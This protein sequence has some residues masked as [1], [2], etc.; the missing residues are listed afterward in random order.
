MFMRQRKP[1]MRYLGGISGGG[2]LK[3]DGEEITRVSYELDGF[4]MEPAGVTRCGEIRID[5]DALKGV[6]GRDGVQLL[7]DDGRLFDLSFSDKELIPAADAVH[8]D[9]TGGMSAKPGKQR[10]RQIPIRAPHSPG[11]RS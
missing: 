3:R 4:Y 11:E 7:T 10:R 2:V 1:G 9:V 5:A 6:F 8:V